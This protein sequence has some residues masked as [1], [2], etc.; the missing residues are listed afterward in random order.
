MRSTAAVLAAAALVGTAGACGGSGGREAQPAAEAP[1]A[2][3]VPAHMTSRYDDGRI[4]V[5]YPGS[6]TQS[7]SSRF[8]VVFAD[9]S[10]R[11]SGFVSV[12]YLPQRELP[13]ARSF[14]SFAADHVRPRGRLLHLYTQAARVGGLGGV[15]AAFIWPLAGTRGPLF[16]VYGFDR[17]RHGVALLIFASENPERHA[18][19]FG[20]VKRAIVWRREPRHERGRGPRP[21]KHARG[22]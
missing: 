2:E 6:W 18:A 20:W 1:P 9:N 13:A 8:G 16:R 10:G 7:R 5:R 4:G 3:F 14:A 21:G 22:Y 17:G 15:E 12:R 19:D 11:H